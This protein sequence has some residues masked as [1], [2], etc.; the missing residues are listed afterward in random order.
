MLPV[1]I[2]E[3]L[4]FNEVA[5]MIPAPTARRLDGKAR[6]VINPSEKSAYRSSALLKK[7]RTLLSGF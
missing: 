6:C 3:S 7:R 2:S 4:Y 5:P 1:E